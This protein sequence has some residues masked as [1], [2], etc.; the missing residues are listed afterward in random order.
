MVLP[1]RERRA[2]LTV[3]DHLALLDDDVDI[4]ENV[5]ATTRTDIMAE[6]VALRADVKWL[7]RTAIGFL[8][9]TVLLILAAVANLALGAV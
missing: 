8:I 1:R 7:T 2:S 9:S 4:G 6:I 5:V 3:S